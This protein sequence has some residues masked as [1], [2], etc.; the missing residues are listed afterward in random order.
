M[1]NPQW[2]LA[3]DASCGRC[4]QIAEIAAR[5]AGDR[6]QVLPLTHPDVMRWRMQGFGN[7]PPWAPTL[8]RVASM[9]GVQGWAGAAMVGPIVRLLGVGSV[10][11]LLRGLGSLPPVEP[12]GGAEAGPS[13]LRR[14]GL[15]PVGFAAVF[16]A[17]FVG[18][19]MM[20]RPTGDGGGDD[21]YRWVQE[22]L[23]RLPQDYDGV[24]AHPMN[25]RRAIYVHLSP[26]ARS[27]LWSE[28]LRRYVAEHPDLTPQQREVLETAMVFA[29][30]AVN[31]AS[32]AS[33]ST[34]QHE[35]LNQQADAAFGRDQATRLFAVLGADTSSSELI[36]A[37][38]RGCTCSTISDKCDNSTHCDNS[39]QC[40]TNGGCGFL[41]SYECNGLC[42]N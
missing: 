30:D 38:R 35:P 40:D 12:A 34:G 10:I 31:F 1:S 13:H 42:V 22:N 39:N 15:S 2:I 27:R 17:V 5:V 32:R 16:A 28:Q 9:G 14:R 29:A 24:T 6:M 36:P 21:A 33:V 41:W 26:D 7:N 3:F 11:Q 23:N 8:L 37:G 18:W 4:R 20:Y 19:Q 25:Y